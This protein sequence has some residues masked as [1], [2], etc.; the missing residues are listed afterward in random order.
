MSYNEIE[1]VRPH[2]RN[3]DTRFYDPNEIYRTTLLNRIKDLEDNMRYLLV[4]N[5]ILAVM[6]TVLTLYIINVI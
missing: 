3:I 4:M 2:Y 1:N 5:G 6:V